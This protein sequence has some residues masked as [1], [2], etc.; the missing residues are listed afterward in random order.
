MDTLKYTCLESD[1][2]AECETKTLTYKERLLNELNKVLLEEGN[3]LRMKN[4][5]RYNV[6]Y[7]GGKGSGLPKSGTGLLCD[8]KNAQVSTIKRSNPPFDTSVLRDYL[9]KK[10]LFEKRRFSSCAVIASAG[11]LKNS[12]LGRIIGMYLLFLL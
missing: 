11:S 4:G 6:R 2:S 1:S 12:N 10:E 8:L 7:V 9:P 5:N 3:V